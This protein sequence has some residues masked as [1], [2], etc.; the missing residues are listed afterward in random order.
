MFLVF[1][2]TVSKKNSVDVLKKVDPFHE[3]EL[4]CKKTAKN[5]TASG[6]CQEKFQ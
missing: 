6:I 1:N 2:I 4:S 3:K 5:T